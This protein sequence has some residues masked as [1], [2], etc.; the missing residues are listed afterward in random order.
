LRQRSNM[1][2][3]SQPL[4]ELI[5][6]YQSLS[7]PPQTEESD[8]TIHV[9]EIASKVAVFYEKI[10]GIID[11]KEEHLLRTGAIERMLKRKIF[12][13]INISNGSYSDENVAEPFILELIRGGI[14]PNDKIEESKIGAVKKILDKYIFVINNSPKNSG[15][16]R[17]QLCNWILSIAACE[18]E[19]S[20]GGT[21]KENALIEF[22]FDSLRQKIKISNNYK[23]NPIKEEDADIQT[24]VAVQ[25]ALFKL[26][27]PAISYRI[28]KYKHPDWSVI[29]EADLLE[30]SKNIYIIW[31]KIEKMLNHRLGDKFYRLCE[32][33]NAPY[34]ILGDII[35][36]NQKDAL[37][38]ISNPKSLESSVKKAYNAR[39][40]SLNSRLKRAAIYATISIFVTKILLALAVEI[41]LDRYIFGNFNWL[42]IGIDA[43][44]PPLLMFF[45]I[46][47]IKPPKRENLTVI[48][49]ELM[50]IVYPPQKE[51]IYELKISKKRNIVFVFFV[52]ILYLISFAIS[53]GFIIFLLYRLSFP[54][55]SYF[56]FI[57][58]IS[59]IAFT[60]T[61]LRQRSKELSIVEEKDGFLTTLLDL[62]VLPLVQLGNWMALR[63]KKYNFIA[64]GFNIL[65]DMPFSVFVEFIEQWRYFLKEKKEKIH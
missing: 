27:S 31:S 64:A 7:K 61:K 52:K 11:W 9:D 37:D 4:Q 62:F 6:K 54:I 22:M 1:P 47:T 19:E 3:L 25:R 28:I 45:I 33:H 35:S 8:P 41:P 49:M 16:P 2:N 18:I 55:I 44:F 14:F 39:L 32:K 57:I 53:L 24:Y 5:R 34:L 10:R 21:E 48:L 42:A 15:K 65:I 63:W 23:K 50:K 17:V 12:S 29:S 36:E 40:A 58:F 46:A 60:G 13:K 43:L 59:L 51:E 26:D 38:K 30:V 20:L 56:V